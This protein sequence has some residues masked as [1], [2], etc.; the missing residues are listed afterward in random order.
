MKKLTLG[1]GLRH[2]LRF[3]QSVRV[4]SLTSAYVLLLVLA[5]PAWPGEKYVKSDSPVFLEATPDRALVYF[6]YPRPQPGTVKVYLDKTPIG[7]LPRKSY[8]AVRVEPA[9]RLVWGPGNSEWFE[10]KRGR[11]YLL[12][13]FQSSQRVGFT[14]KSDWFM[15]NPD[16]IRPLVLQR[17]LAHVRTPEAGLERLKAELDKKYKKAL[18]Q[19]GSKGEVV[20]PKWFSP[21]T[22]MAKGTGKELL[23]TLFELPSR[24]GTLTIGEQKIE[25]RSKKKEVVIPVTEIRQVSL[26][27]FV[28]EDPQPWIFVRYGPAEAPN[29]AFFRGNSY[30]AIFAAIMSAMEIA[31]GRAIEPVTAKRQEVISP[32]K[33][34]TVSKS[35]GETI[36]QQGYRYSIGKGVP[37]DHATALLWYRKAAQEGHAGAQYNLGAAYANGAGVSADQETA[38]DWF[39]KA[40]QSFLKEG[41]REQARQAVAA[42]ERVAPGHALGQRLRAAIQ[43][44]SQ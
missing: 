14:Y 12:V 25:Y 10:F 39:F 3:R 37:K 9:Y 30:N 20:L 18:K 36:Y 21:A 38:V 19:A 13:Y 43:A 31:S 1:V 2:L 22:Y 29:T 41:N 17:K 42:I 11:T 24:S 28:T 4:L 5:A 33:S 26:A 7:F 6:V 27:G 15:D 32:I 34:G 40:G 35:P 8:T 23:K 44:Q 16:L